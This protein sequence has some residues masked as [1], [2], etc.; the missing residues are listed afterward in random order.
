MF[1]R[2][3][4]ILIYF[5]EQL[6]RTHDI[7]RVDISPLLKQ[8]FSNSEISTAISWFYDNIS[9]KS[10]NY[11]TPTENNSF[12]IFTDDEQLMFTK[13]AWAD[14]VRLQA[15]GIL[16]N[17]DLEVIIEKL[18][19]AGPSKVDVSHLRHYVAI[20]IFNAELSENTSSKYLLSASDTIH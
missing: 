5:I 18:T 9:L 10:T 6:E 4:E 7:E 1:E 2:I 15:M 14:L 8:G 3:I 17:D 11:I 12:R 13:E 16:T 20:K 19:F